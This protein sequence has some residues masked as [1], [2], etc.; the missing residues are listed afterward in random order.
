MNSQHTSIKFTAEFEQ[1]DKLPFLD[2]LV[3]RNTT[4]FETSVFRKDTF[5]GLG[6]SFF[7]FCVYKFKINAIKTL[8][9]R[10]YNICSNYQSLH[11]EFKFLI[12][13]FVSNGFPR[14]L[15]EK[16]IN[17][18]LNDKFN[19]PPSISTVA[20]KEFFFPLPY[21][22]HQSLK[23]KSELEHLVAKYVPHL[24]LKLVL[25]NNFKIGNLFKTKDSI[26]TCLRSN[27]IYS[28]RCVQSN[29]TSEYIGS[30]T[31]CLKLRA[32]EHIGI[33]CR[34][35]RPLTS[36]VQSAVRDHGARCP[37]GVDFDN[38]SILDSA[39]GS[40]DL[41]ILESLYIFKS[42][43]NLN[44]TLSAFPLLIFNH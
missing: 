38:F 6:I 17:Y 37:G 5:S 30:T 33:S 44:N 25:T 28:F 4:G 19:S 15:I 31:R 16:H 32:S 40:I 8:L 21:F 24:D 26:P 14:Q 13:F 9:F 43:P 2:C 35:G 23:M 7:S 20:K 39:K 29:C 10:A 22:G 12:Q 1:N 34:T 3:K 11:T 41:R 18:F 27:I 42:K 36:P